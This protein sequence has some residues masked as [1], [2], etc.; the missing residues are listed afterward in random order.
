MTISGTNVGLRRFS[1]LTCFATLFLI[2]V[3]G[4][5]TSTG[6]GLAVPDWPL[7]YGSLFP[8]MVGGVFY[9]HGHRIVAALVGI[10]TFFL[11]VWLSLAQEIR[12]VR[13]LGF[14]ALGCVIAQGVVGGL[15]VLF[16]LPM[17][18]S[19]YHAVLAQTFFI[20]TLFIAYS[21]SSERESMQE[22]AK[23][24]APAVLKLS[25]LLSLLVYVQLI[26]GALMRHTGCG[27]AIHLIQA[28]AIVVVAGQ[29][30]A[31]CIQSCREKSRVPTLILLD[32]L[33]MT[34]IVLGVLTVLIQKTA[35]VASLHVVTGAAVLGVS[36]LMLLRLAPLTW[37]ETGEL[38]FVR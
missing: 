18:L 38:L 31:A 30:S 34:Q 20:F 35:I 32:L 17:V 24:T 21:Q 19:V 10:L 14:C 33:L 8:P 1:K 3:G 2:F 36:V 13:R 12:W 4:M 23:E 5:V 7:S 28:V 15:T 27:L 22:Q 37:K 25:L 26:L 29:L 6:S 16:F 11:T 9:E